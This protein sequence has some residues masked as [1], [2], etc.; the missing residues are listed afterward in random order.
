M[1]EALAFRNLLSID[2]APDSWFLQLSFMALAQFLKG[3]PCVLVENAATGARVAG[4]VLQ[5]GR[6]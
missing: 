5:A 3:S 2:F 6:D 4:I 1:C